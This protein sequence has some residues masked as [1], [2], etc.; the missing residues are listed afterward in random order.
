MTGRNMP[1]GLRATSAQDDGI[2]DADDG[3]KDWFARSR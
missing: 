3:A 1:K 2:A